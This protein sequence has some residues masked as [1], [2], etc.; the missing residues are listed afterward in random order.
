MTERAPYTVPGAL[1]DKPFSAEKKLLQ[2]HPD[3]NLPPCEGGNYKGGRCDRDATYLYGHGTYCPAHLDW[4]RAGEEEDELHMGLH[5]AKRM[6]WQAQVVGIDKLEEHLQQAVSELAEE[7]AE[8]E[9][10]VER[11]RAIA[12][13]DP[14]AQS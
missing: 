10:H 5:H 14:K 6:L 11:I 9:R 12:E 13:S 2:P 1:K 7:L 8:N 4:I 3:G